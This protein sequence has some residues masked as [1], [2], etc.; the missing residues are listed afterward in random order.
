MDISHADGADAE[1][2]NVI[3]WQDAMGDKA[4]PVLLKQNE[5]EEG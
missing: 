2:L 1:Q 3:L 4:V 5:K